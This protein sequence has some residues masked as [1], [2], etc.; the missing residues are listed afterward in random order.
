MLLRPIDTS[1]SALCTLRHGMPGPA[2]PAR[3]ARPGGPAAERPGRGACGAGAARRRAGSWG[4]P[5]WAS[6]TDITHFARESGDTY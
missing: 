5:G 1:V 4:M 3:H 2:C 6:C